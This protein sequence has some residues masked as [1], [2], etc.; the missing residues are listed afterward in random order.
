MLK[1]REM[2]QY[3]LLVSFLVFFTAC[4]HVSSEQSVVDSPTLLRALDP[5]GFAAS[6]SKPHSLP[7]GVCIFF[8]TPNTD[9]SAIEEREIME[10]LRTLLAESNSVLESCD[11]HLAL[12][13]IQVVALPDRLLDMQGNARGSS[14]GHPPAGTA[15]PELFSYKENERLTGEAR[16][17]FGYGK[18]YTKPNTIAVF[19]VRGIEY[20]IGQERVEAYG[21][22]FPPNR[23]HHVDDYPL[24]NSVL[25]VDGYVGGVFAGD[26]GYTLAHELAHMLLNSG[27]HFDD[28]QN[29]MGAGLELTTAQCYRMRQNRERLYGTSAVPDPGPPT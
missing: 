22:S 4:E 6:P 23:Y 12:E 11:M 29:L 26:S 8:T 14:G 16:E 28:P 24:R 21:K 10:H 13:T 5:K 27:S 9:Y 2:H 17:L 15:N 7:V 18:Q 25:L 3:F 19:A 1:T 20:Y